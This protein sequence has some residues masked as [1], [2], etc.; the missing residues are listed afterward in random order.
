LISIV[1]VNWN[2][3]R[4]LYDLV[5]SILK[6]HNNVIDSLV[7]IDNAS[8]D[9]SLSCV[10]AI[11]DPPFGVKIIGNKTNLGFA[12]AC[13]QGAA[14]AASKYL[15]FLNPDTRLFNDS[16]PTAVRFMEKKVNG[17]IAVAGVKLVDEEGRVSRSCSRFPCLAMF[18]AKSAGVNRL[19]R[20]PRLSQRMEEWEHNVTR[21]VDQV[22]GAFFL[23][24]REVFESLGGFDERFFMYFEE[25]D[26]SLR[27]RDAGWGSIFIADAEVFH[28][29]GGCSIQV[30]PS[31]LF[32][33]LRSRLLFGFKHFGILQAMLLLFVTLQLEAVSR[34]MLG[35]TQGKLEDVRN[36]LK[37][38]G[39]LYRDLPNV[40]RRAALS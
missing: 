24:R 39:M 2:S 13:N 38:Y 3:G 19:F 12:A 26:L 1:I 35:I 21:Q 32:Y 18:F 36:T 11:S 28:A 17:H 34:L 6:C 8:V 15:L 23:I 29:G 22:M 16:L 33:S 31:R 27:A 14:L 25:V 20:C 37:A 4:Q 30:Q 5:C 7:I 10:K 9:N 40:F